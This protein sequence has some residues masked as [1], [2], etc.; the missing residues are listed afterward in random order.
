MTR[1]PSDAQGMTSAQRIEAL[2]ARVAELEADLRTLRAKVDGT[3][4]RFA[5][6]YAGFADRFRGS[7]AEVTA[8]LATYLPDVHR[9]LAAVPGEVVDL[10]SGRGE[11]L[12]LLRDEGLPASGVDSHPDFVESAR[13]RGLNVVLG[14]AVTHLERLPPASVAVVTAFH[15]IEHVDVEVLLTLLAAARAALRPGGAVLLETPNPTNLRMAACDFYNDPTHRRPL[16]PALTEYLVTASGFVD[17]EVR[18]VNPG[19]PP[20]APTDRRP[21][22]RWV[23]DALYGPQDYAVLGHKP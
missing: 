19:R 13:E 8:K 10:G 14:D 7:T 5:A 3:G 11:W 21:V 23:V 20:V 18:A 15:L 2:E 4:P 9:L 17:V 16:P 1:A 12:T 22:E 6:L